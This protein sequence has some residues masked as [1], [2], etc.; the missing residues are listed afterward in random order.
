MLVAGG[1]NHLRYLSGLELFDE[2][3]A[4]KSASLVAPACI[5]CVSRFFSDASVLPGSNVTIGIMRR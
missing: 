4:G 2:N 1:D 5:S 3:D